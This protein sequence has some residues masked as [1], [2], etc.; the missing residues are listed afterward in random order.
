MI[1]NGGMIEEG[2]E[3]EEEERRGLTIIASKGA[4]TIT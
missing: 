4:K 3:E 2:G 1:D